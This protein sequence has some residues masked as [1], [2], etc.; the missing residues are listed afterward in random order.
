MV[1]R[2]YLLVCVWDVGHVLLL[3]TVTI[4]AHMQA[5]ALGNGHGGVQLSEWGVWRIQKMN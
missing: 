1:W 2:V 3:G 5:L 4:T